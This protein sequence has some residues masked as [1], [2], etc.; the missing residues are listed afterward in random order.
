MI[1]TRTCLV[2]GA[3]A[4]AP[5]GY[6]VGA[7]LTE[8][9]KSELNP[10][11]P[12]RLKNDLMSA[13]FSSERLMLF[14][15][16][17]RYSQRLSIDAFLEDWKEDFMDVGTAAIAASLIRWE[18]P[19]VVIDQ[20]N[21]YRRLFH[22]MTDGDDFSKNLLRIVTFNYDRSLEFFF[23]WALQGRYRISG[24]EAA[25]WFAKFPI[26]HMYGN[27]GSLPGLFVDGRLYGEKGTPA[28]IS[29]AIDSREI[30]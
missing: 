29:A 12:S 16:A 22:E 7:A 9:I 18:D 20:P 21:W 28:I 10:S 30:E 5:F 1:T 23:Y 27:L 26:V 11:Q 3:G 4:S 14:R 15:D 6:P 17:L 13:G 25:K 8:S 2:L 19:D 24:E